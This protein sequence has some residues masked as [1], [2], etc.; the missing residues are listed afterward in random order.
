MPVRLP[1]DANLKRKIKPRVNFQYYG[2]M[3]NISLS[4]KKK[5]YKICR[6]KFEIYPE[7]TGYIVGL[8]EMIIHPQKEE[9][10]SFDG[11]FGYSKSRTFFLFWYLYYY[12]TWLGENNV[13]SKSY[14][15][16]QHI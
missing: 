8:F 4:I 14:S 12:R 5:S 3:W 13:G 16:T 6:I 11:K 9:I 2:F 7:F 15:K 10:N 1:N